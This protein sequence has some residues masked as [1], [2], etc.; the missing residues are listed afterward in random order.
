MPTTVYA[1]EWFSIET[2]EDADGEGR[3]FFRIRQPD[4][5]AVLAFT[6]ADELILVRQY[7]WAIGQNTLESPAGHVDQG[8]KPEEA[9]ARELFEETGYRPGNLRSLGTVRVC[10]H[11][12]G[13]LDHLFLATEARLEP[14]M[15]PEDGIEVV[16]ADRDRF[17]ALCDDDAMSQT[18]MYAMLKLAEIRFGFRWP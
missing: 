2:S 11:R 18:D 10:A 1:N 3:P 4:N 6:T 15:R 14:G 16:L 12:F 17:R 9:A 13:H 7:R 5:V 8:E